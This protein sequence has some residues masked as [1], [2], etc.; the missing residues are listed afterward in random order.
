MK[1]QKSDNLVVLVV[2]EPILPS[3]WSR[4]TRPVLGR[5]SD[6]RV[7][8]FWDKDH[9]I[10][11]QLSAQL[12]TK[13]PTCCRHSGTLWDLVAL[14]PKDTSWNRSEPTYVDG[15]VYKIETELQSQTSKLLQ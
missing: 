13:Q 9:L 3:D 2:W 11:K 8:Q 4:P 6:N 7:I 14:Y 5:I 1:Q 10:A 15:P 12:H